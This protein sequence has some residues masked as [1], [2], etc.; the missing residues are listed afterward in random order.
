[1]Q[2][3]LCDQGE[4]RSNSFSDTRRTIAKE[5]C[6]VFLLFLQI[7]LLTRYCFFSLLLSPT[8]HLGK[9]DK[10]E[11][12]KECS[13]EKDG[14]YFPTTKIQLGREKRQVHCSCVQTNTWCHLPSLSLSPPFSF[15][16]PSLLPRLRDQLQQEEAQYMSELTSLQE[17]P[18]ERQA[19]MR[20]R[21]KMLKD[22]REQERLA[23]VEDKLEQRWRYTVMSVV[24]MK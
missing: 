1:M 16:S 23:L 17:T 9:R 12:S 24:K 20:E 21:A 8:D 3:V 10:Q 18:L 19:K 6:T 11:N 7:I 4:R 2:I 22:R 15:L 14:E 13:Q 5:C